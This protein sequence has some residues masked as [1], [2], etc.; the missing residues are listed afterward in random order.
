MLKRMWTEKERRA[1]LASVEMKQAS[2]LLAQGKIADAKICM[3]R[4]KS[5]LRSGFVRPIGCF[6][7]KSA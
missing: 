1:F 3:F 7:K 5:I 4:A 2:E 6:L